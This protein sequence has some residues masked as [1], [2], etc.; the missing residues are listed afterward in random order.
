MNMIVKLLNNLFWASLLECIR[1]QRNYR[2]YYTFLLFSTLLCL[3]IH[4]FCWVYVTRI[5][6]FEEISI[7]R[8]MIKTPASVALVI[9]SFVC[10]WFVG[11]LT[12]FHTY[13]IS[14]NK[15][16]YENFKNRYGQQANP[17]D[18]GIIENFKQV[19]CTSIP[20]SKN[21][22]RSKIPILKEP[23]D[24]SQSSSSVHPLI[25]TR[26]TRGDLE[27]GMRQVYNETNKQ[28][29]DSR[30]GFN[31][32]EHNKDVGPAMLLDLRR[33]LHTEGGD[34]QDTQIVVLPLQERTNK[35]LDISHD[36]LDR[37]PIV[38]ES[39]RT[40]GSDSSNCPV[41]TQL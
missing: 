32:E 3:Y 11:G 31:N 22:F 38:E 19:F 9:Y 36:I 34:A 20:P 39:N 28:E 10:V 1:L 12:V 4:A 35:K 40:A 41:R 15:S 2:Y 6:G 30:D 26:K 25:K 23:S 5:M 29:I 14:T 27:F 33:A 24:L 13:L 18:R 21:K 8:A 7:W 17:Y 16:T 37:V